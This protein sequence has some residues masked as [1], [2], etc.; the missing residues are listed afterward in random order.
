LDNRLPSSQVSVRK[1]DF[2]L[3]SFAG[4][5]RLLSIQK[6]RPIRW[7]MPAHTAVFNLR[8][9]QEA[10]VFGHCGMPVIGEVAK[11]GVT[12]QELHREECSS[13]S[14]RQDLSGTEMCQIEMQER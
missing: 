3:R 2:R 11:R 5:A 4:Q 14:S 6:Y 10:V 12:A 1:A 13:Q 9:S 7:T 8:S